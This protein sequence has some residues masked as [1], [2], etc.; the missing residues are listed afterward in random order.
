MNYKLTT[1]VCRLLECSPT[2]LANYLSRH[3]ELK[4]AKRLQ[5]AFF[6]TDAEIE[7][8][9]EARAGHLPGPKARPMPDDDN[10]DYGEILR[11][12]AAEPLEHGENV[13]QPESEVVWRA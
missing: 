13:G 5:T 8:V 3:P 1:D 9:R 4:P 6:W 7:R 10:V 2:A 12:M 11:Q